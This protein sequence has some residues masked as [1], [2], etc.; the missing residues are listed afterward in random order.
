MPVEED[1]F[2][3]WAGVVAPE[4]RESCMSARRFQNTNNLP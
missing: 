2:A 4:F 3:R 1:I